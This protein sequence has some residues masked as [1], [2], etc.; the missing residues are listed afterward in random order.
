MGHQ[1]Q[2]GP[3]A[4]VAGSCLREGRRAERD[5]VIKPPAGV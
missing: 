1:V 4:P 2:V 5:P 3:G